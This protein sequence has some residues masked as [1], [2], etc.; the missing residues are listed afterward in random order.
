[1]S[2]VFQLSWKGVSSSSKGFQGYLKEGSM[3]F[4]KVSKKFQGSFKTVKKKFQGYFKIV[5]KKIEEYWKGDFS[6]VQG[7]LKDLQREVQGSLKVFQ[8]CFKEISRFSNKVLRMLIK[9]CFNGVCPDSCQED[10]GQTD[11]SRQVS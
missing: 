8:G 11:V 7:H 1:M 9:G 10:L 6:G 4:Q 2:T 3:V 5:S